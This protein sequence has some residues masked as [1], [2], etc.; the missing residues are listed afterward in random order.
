MKNNL[1]DYAQRLHRSN[2]KFKPGYIKCELGDDLL[3]IDDEGRLI[4]DESRLLDVRNKQD[5]SENPTAGTVRKR[6]TTK[7]VFYS[8]QS[9]QD[10]GKGSKRSG[11]WRYYKSRALQKKRSGKGV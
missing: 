3:Y 6:S 9:G 7:K 10:S 2:P 1:E 8:E 4:I 11:D 5:A